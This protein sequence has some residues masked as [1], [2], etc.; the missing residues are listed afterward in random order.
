M[1]IGIHGLN[2]IEGNFLV[3]EAVIEG[4]R[5]RAAYPQLRLSASQPCQ[6]VPKWFLP[7]SM[8][9][10]PGRKQLVYQRDSL[11]ESQRHIS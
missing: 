3:D 4:E 2:D 7:K 9:T 8:A 5:E 1:S 10:L 11:M 6:M